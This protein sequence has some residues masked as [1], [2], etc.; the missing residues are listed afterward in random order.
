MKY[1]SRILVVDDQALMR[2]HMHRLLAREGYELSFASNGR[3][4]LELVAQFSPDLVLLDVRMPEMDGFEVCQR[5]RENALTADLPIIMVTAFDDRDARLRGIEAGADDFI[6]KPYDS[7]ELRAR[8]R[9]ITRLNRYRRMMGERTKFHLLAERS[10][11]GYLLLNDHDHCLY[12]NRQARHYLGLAQEEALSPELSFTAHARLTYHLE[13]KKAWNSWPGWVKNNTPRYL[14]RS[15][16][17]ERPAMWL[18]VD[19]IDYLPSGDEMAWVVSLQD[20]TA[21][22]TARHEMWKFQRAIQHK[23]RT[24]LVGLVSGLQFVSENLAELSK[25]EIG[26]FVNMALRDG[27]RFHKSVEDVLTYVKTPDLAHHGFGFPLAQLRE[28]GENIGRLLAIPHPLQWHGLEQIG[29][30]TIVLSRQSL[31]LILLELMENSKKFHPEHDP[32]ISF[33]LNLNRPHTAAIQICDNGRTLSPEQLAQVW[34]PYYQAEKNFVGE[35]AGMGLG[36][37]TVAS[38]VWS[39]GG[40]CRVYNLT[41]AVGVGVE[42]VLPLAEL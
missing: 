25:E 22:M 8:V 41:S 38:L 42:L 35:V 17:E 4:A 7:L 39:V 23:M 40:Q 29:E 24:P 14:V 15:E 16:T 27:E 10:A 31:E 20:V 37:P 1:Q 32:Q 2:E 26:E 18:L 30:E 12:A 33:Y 28:L 34:S 9:T 19:T 21:Q 36:L 3:E 6:P 11:T 13:S 5:I